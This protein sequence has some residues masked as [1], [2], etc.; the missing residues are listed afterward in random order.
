MI[1]LEKVSDN[2]F[3]KIR[4]RFDG[5]SLYDK[6]LKKTEDQEQARYFVFNY[7]ASDNVEYGQITM[8]LGEDRNLLV[9]YD[10]SLDDKMP[11]DVK[12]E[13]YTFLKS[14]RR[15]AR[16]NRCSYDVRDITKDGLELRDLKHIRKDQN[17]FAA[18]DIVS[19]GRL[20]GTTRSSYEHL[21]PTKIIVR[22]S[23]KVDEEILG[24]RSRNVAAI[25]VEN[26]LGERF[27]LPEGTSVSEARAYARH[28]KNGGKVDDEFGKHITNIISE[29]KSLRT[30]VRNMRGRQFEDAETQTMVETAID[31]YGGLHRDLHSLKGQRG[32]NRYVEA[33][34][35]AQEVLADDVN[36]E[37]LRA[38]F[39]RRIFDDRMSSALPIVARAYK[40]RRNW[41]ES[42][43]NE[44]ASGVAG[45]FDEDLDE[46]SEAYTHHQGIRKQSGL[47]NPDY[48]TA[49]KKLYDKNLNNEISD[50][51][52]DQLRQQLKQKYNI[53]EN[54]VVDVEDVEENIDSYSVEA[55]GDIMPCNDF[56]H[57]RNKAS[58][59]LSYNKAEIVY[60]LKNG[61]RIN[62]WRLGEKLQD[63]ADIKTRLEQA[64]NNTSQVE[65]SWK[66][67][68]A[69][70]ALAA[71][72]LMSPGAQSTELEVKPIT[73]ATVTIGD[74]VRRYN[75][76]DK[77]ANS[78]E[79]EKFISNILDKQ[80]LSGYTLDIKH[81]YPKKDAEL[82][83]DLRKWFKE[84]WVRF[85]PDGKIRGDCARGSESEGKPKCLP[86]SKAHALGKQ[87][88]ASSAAK[89]RREDPNPE[90][91]GAAKNVATK[92]NEQELEEKWSEKYKGSINCNDPKG[93][94]QRAHCQGKNKNEEVELEERK[95]K[96]K[97]SAYYAYWYPGFG[98]YA[99]SGEGSEGGGGDGGGGESVNE[100]TCPACG[101]AIVEHSML[102]EKKD[103]CYYKV[104]SRYKV[105]PSAYASGALVKCRKKGAK[106]WGTKKED[107]QEA[108]LGTA[109]AWPELVDKLN[110]VLKAIGWRGN[111]QDEN[112]FT[113]LRRGLNEDEWYTVL[114]EN[115]GDGWFTYALGTVEEGD[116]YI[117]QEEMLP[118][119]EAS[120]SMLMDEIREGFNLAES[121]GPE[122]IRV[123]QLPQDAVIK[124]GKVLGK[125]P[126]K[127]RGLTGKLVGEIENEPQALGP[128]LYELFKTPK[129]IV[130]QDLD[131]A[132]AGDFDKLF[133]D[134]HINFTHLGGKYILDSAAEAAR[135]KDLIASDALNNNKKIKYPKLEVKKDN[136]LTGA[137]TWERSPVSGAK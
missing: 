67:K 111:R 1:N 57:A 29:M 44:W 61:K 69:G 89:K 83:E 80:G 100:T 122:Q 90:R 112:T 49:L 110:K 77:F 14:L 84:K 132:D 73:I 40:Q 34:Q 99:G 62:S 115:E 58:K 125:A 10:M 91:K 137:S 134:N 118:L 4:S 26:H 56:D 74:E 42:E 92:T 97:R 15:F 19:E 47:P 36:L 120:L 109:I 133:Q 105:W 117:G 119:T 78:K 27:R 37:E 123:G 65:E 16:R 95:K 24:A 53:K 9:Y 81:G 121:L 22:H 108:S 127:Q 85:G 33:W 3:N 59:L 39:E 30:F 94:S 116:P 71:T 5:V 32:Y 31:Y 72:N 13:W 41:A 101:G 104:K 38:R 25:Y 135:A 54:L 114:I 21:G 93:F 17:V 64:L 124:T 46:E 87:G 129:K 113:F 43:F 52:L 130:E 48:Y 126:Q 103:A 8:H 86:Q 45:Q 75:L 88:R 107:I 20:S 28:V 63:V 70:A 2:L 76:G 79:A 35:P 136:E 18:G 131:L 55:N 60:I 6:S 12:P 68:L 11:D 128:L 82:N 106:N 96:S 66:S 23:K 50:Q 51:E 7:T 98:Y 102:N